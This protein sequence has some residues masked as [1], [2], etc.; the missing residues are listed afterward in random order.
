MSVMMPVVLRDASSAI[1]AYARLLEL[2]THLMTGRAVQV[3][4]IDAAASLSFSAS[5]VLR[6]R[7]EAVR[8][9]LRLVALKPD[10]TYVDS[11]CLPGPSLY[12]VP[13]SLFS[14]I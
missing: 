10:I 2:P 12:D 9:G 13:R 4:W 6:M 5:L 3:V 7:A 8:T 1:D 14:R 11:P